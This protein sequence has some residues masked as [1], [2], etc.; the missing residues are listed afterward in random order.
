MRVVH[1]LHKACLSRD[2]VGPALLACS[3]LASRGHE[4]T[5]VTSDPVDIPLE[6]QAG[7]AGC[8][9]VEQI[10]PIANRLKLLSRWSR[11]FLEVRLTGAQLLHLHDPYEAGADRA[12]MIARKVGVPVVSGFGNAGFRVLLTSRSDVPG[13][14]RQLD[15][16]TAERVVEHIE[17]L[18]AR[19]LDGSDLAISAARH[20]F[21]ARTA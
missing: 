15:P 5:I 11:R 20:A 10:P 18:Y 16:L 21:L 8:P 9:R 3:A 19:T 2:A 14:S 6:W 17:S 4:V 1:Y 13:H 12:A 7:T